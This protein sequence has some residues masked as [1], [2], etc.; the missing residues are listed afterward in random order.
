MEV[1]S[2]STKYNT[3]KSFNTLLG[4]AA[5]VKH[6]GAVGDG[7]TDDT[8]AI[9][10][11]LDS[12]KNVYFPSGTYLVSSLN[13]PVGVSVL[14]DGFSTIFKQKSGILT[15]TVVLKVTG[16]YV[17]IESCKIQGNIATD[18]GEQRHG[19]LCYANSTVGALTG[20]RIGDIIGE[21]LRG[22]VVYI[23]NGTTGETIKD[24][25][26][27][28]VFGLNCYRNVVSITGGSNINVQSVTGSA[29]G[30]YM[31]DIESNS[32]GGVISDVTINYCK[33]HS[34]QVACPTLTDY[35]TGIKINHLDINL[36]HCAYSTPAMPR[37]SYADDGLILRN[38]KSILIDYAKIVGFN[39]MAINA[40]KNGGDLGVLSLV[41]NYLEMSDCSK[42]DTTYYAYFLGATDPVVRYL[43]VD[44]T[45]SNVRVFDALTGG[46]FGTIKYTFS[47]SVSLFRNCSNVDITNLNATG[48]LGGVI[49]NS[50]NIRI[51]N[52]S[53]TSVYLA[54]GSHKCEFI[55]V[56]ATCSSYIFNGGATDHFVK[57]STL[58]AVYYADGFYERVYTM[59][60]KFGA[61][62]LWVDSGGLLRLKNGVP[63]SETD[64][65]VV[66]TQT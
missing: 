30:L 36:A 32:G 1:K 26:V 56:T 17:T 40:I 55:N 50:N 37:G 25:N 18:T 41:F 47:E 46:T 58:N 39:R 28:S 20:I 38:I 29:V 52:G 2:L 63:A 21:N 23:G 6:F 13:V 16:S 59:S 22:D 51:L 64:G 61:Y 14:T 54:S 4:V 53:V 62:S 3:L 11:V 35:A 27:G 49:S 45:R 43:K 24:C 33:G 44:A 5:N 10:S 34:A 66:G 42:T 60:L 31:F 15:D 8:T 7:I 57:N 12:K 48:T 65:T 9:Q 19:I